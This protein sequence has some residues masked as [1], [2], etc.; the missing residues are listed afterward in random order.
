MLNRDLIWLK[1]LGEE[2]SGLTVPP[3]ENCE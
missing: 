3:S 1:T 2:A